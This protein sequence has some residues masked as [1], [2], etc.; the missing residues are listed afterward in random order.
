MMGR[1]RL[2]CVP[3]AV[4]VAAGLLFV[5]G[6]SMS[7]RGR[8]ILH[9][10]A[11]FSMPLLIGGCGG[12]AT[13]PAPTTI[14]VTATA[15]TTM[16]VTTA[17]PPTTA[18]VLLTQTVASTVTVQA[19]DTSSTESVTAAPPPPPPAATSAAPGCH[20]LTNGGK[21]YEPGELCRTADHGA[22]GVAG[23]GEGITCQNNNGWRWEPT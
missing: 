9:I 22:T 5:G 16:L 3:S 1:P 17:I 7:V 12:T 20:P 19:A 21:C 8:R 10:G 13:Q 11:A 2:G 18:T 23:D 6:V 4:W 15:T 14:T